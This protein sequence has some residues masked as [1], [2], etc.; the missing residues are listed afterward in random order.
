MV[1]PD[2]T[3]D[4]LFRLY[5]VAVGFFSLKTYVSSY[6]AQPELITSAGAWSLHAFTLIA[7]F[8]IWR[9]ARP[10][11]LLMASV[12]ATRCLIA[13]HRVEEPLLW[14][15]AAE[16]PLFVALPAL[17]LIGMLIDHLKS[18]GVSPKMQASGGA[19][20][21][22]SM[23]DSSS[24]L[25]SF[26][27]SFLG[28]MTWAGL[29]KLNSDFFDPKVSCAR[30]SE[31]LTEWWG[32]PEWIYAHASPVAIVCA[33]L[34]IGV[35]LL[36]RPRWGALGAVLL[37]GHF[38]SIGATALATIVIAMALSFLTPQD[39]Q[40]A[41][42]FPRQKPALSLVVCAGGVTLSWWCYQGSWSWL[43]YGLFHGL[44]SLILMGVI[45]LFFTQIP[46]QRHA[47]QPLGL[48]ALITTYQRFAAVMILGWTLNGL[49]PYLGLK[50][51]YSFAMLSNLRVDDDRWNSYL[52][53]RELRGHSHDGFIHVHEVMY[54]SSS[55]G[56][57]LR[58]GPLRPGLYSPTSLR[59][60]LKSAHDAS[61]SILA[62][63]SYHGEE[64]DF[65]G[66]P[67][68]RLITWLDSIPD[69]SLIQKRLTLKRP[70]SCVH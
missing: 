20:K 15:P 48:L 45:S 57:L 39:V 61:E 42:S 60:Y 18:S 32:I 12:C 68:Q 43:Q 46:T 52:F 40:A 50:F 51:Q 9:G 24:T 49:T 8:I 25:L 7:L 66:Q 16:W 6:T 10:L 22:E 34:G 28:A 19:L 33:E 5:G 36:W 23:T 35:I 62:R 1:A 59:A 26:R 13:T 37:L 69:T 21:I 55:T 44:I 38:G 63:L 29:H 31:R 47:V 53:S 64:H 54:R 41:L 11:L 56:R 2:L 3:R 70:Q 65:M 14:F 4:V 30:L 67:P 27:L 17:A 58:G